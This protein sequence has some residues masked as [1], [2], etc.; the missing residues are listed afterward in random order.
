MTD[1]QNTVAGS[2]LWLH[3]TRPR[4]HWYLVPAEKQGE[5]QAAW[6]AI[7]QAAQGKG[8]LYQGRYHIRGQHDFETVDVWTFA[9]SQAAFD[10]WNTLVS[11]KY[12]EFFAFS[13]NIGL[14]LSGEHGAGASRIE[15][16]L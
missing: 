8:A 7:A 4:P 12:S 14:A 10:Y 1:K 9:S 6:A 13:N 5:L 11:A 3:Y 2:C 15:H 16:R